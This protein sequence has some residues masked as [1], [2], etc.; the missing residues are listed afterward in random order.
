MLIDGENVSNKYADSI[1]ECL[2][3]YGRV[4]IKNAYLSIDDT[5][6]IVPQAWLQT[7][8]NKGMHLV[9]QTRNASGKNCVDS[10]LIIDAMDILHANKDV[11]CFCLASSDSDFTTLA[12]RLR[13]SGK[14]LIGMGEKKT[15]MTLRKACDEFIEL[16]NNID[17]NKTILD[18]YKTVVAEG[19][20][21]PPIPKQFIENAIKNMINSDMAEGRETNLGDV[22]NRLKRMYPDFDTRNYGTAKF[23]KFIASLNGFTVLNNNIVELIEIT[24][25]SKTKNQ[26]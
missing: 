8:K 15:I 24:S 12:S 3:K 25:A 20:N 6:R 10:K 1:L 17:Q 19:E 13:E 2:A 21:V 4:I 26:E 9:T 16:E 14:Y 23:S 11:D 7:C 22:A 5:G 18:K